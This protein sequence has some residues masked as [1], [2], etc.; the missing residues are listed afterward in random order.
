MKPIS[1]IY[2]QNL[3]QSVSFECF[4]SLF[5]AARSQL[6]DLAHAWNLGKGGK[7]WLARDSKSMIPVLSS[8]APMARIFDYLPWFGI[9]FRIWTHVFGLTVGCTAPPWSMEHSSTART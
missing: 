7:G 9:H 1:Q 5:V 4:C 6:G 3:A 8:L 2:D